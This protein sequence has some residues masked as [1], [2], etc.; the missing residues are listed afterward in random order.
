[1]SW[2]AW[3]MLGVLAGLALLG[4]VLAAVGRESMERRGTFDLS[5]RDARRA[6]ERAADVSTPESSG[7]RGSFAGSNDALGKRLRDGA[8]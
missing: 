5:S 4:M 8:A 1:M 3:F 6:F 2:F 7:I